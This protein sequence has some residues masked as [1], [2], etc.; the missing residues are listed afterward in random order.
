MK[1]MIDEL[2][3][4]QERCREEEQAFA[5]AAERAKRLQVWLDGVLSGGPSPADAKNDRRQGHSIYDGS[6]KNPTGVPDDL[7]AERPQP[8]EV[9]LLQCQRR[10]RER[11]ALAG[12]PP[13]EIA[14]EE[15]QRRSA[16]MIES[17]QADRDAGREPTP[18][19]L[20]LAARYIEGE[21]DFEQYSSAVRNL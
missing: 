21:M 1:E 11:R 17:I 13:L 16:Q 4:E 9:S 10:I 19:H 20:I 2:A 7:P 15:R 12:L 5:E 18:L 8:I 14:K 3:N 6:A